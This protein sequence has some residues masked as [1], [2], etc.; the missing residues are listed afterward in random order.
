LGVSVTDAS[1]SAEF[2]DTAPVASEAYY[3]VVAE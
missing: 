2:T 1:G 3:R